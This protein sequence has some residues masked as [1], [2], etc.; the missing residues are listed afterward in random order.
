MH[1]HVW[2]MQPNVLFVVYNWPAQQYPQI[3]RQLNMIGTWWSRNL[4]LVHNNPG[5]GN[6]N[7]NESRKNVEIDVFKCEPSQSTGSFLGPG[8]E[9]VKLPNIQLCRSHSR[10]RPSRSITTMMKK[11]FSSCMHRLWLYVGSRDIKMEQLKLDD[12]LV[13]SVEG[14]PHVCD[15]SKASY[16]DE[17]MKDNSWLSTG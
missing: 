3:S 9:N 5:N 2:L 7:E 1:I 10:A 4:R 13:M 17:I 16:K 14:Y 11:N 6:Q 8:N 12:L 15:K